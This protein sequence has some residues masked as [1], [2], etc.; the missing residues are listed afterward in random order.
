MDTDNIYE[1]M[2]STLQGFNITPRSANRRQSTQGIM[3]SIT[4]RTS[5]VPPQKPGAAPAMPTS[6]LRNGHH[7]LHIYAH[8]HNTHI[9]LTRP[10]REPILSYSAGNIGFRKAQRGSFDAAFQLAA[11][12]MRTISDKGLLR[13]TV[14]A[15][16]GSAEAARKLEAP[17][18]EV[19]VVLRG[20][21]KGREAVVKALLGAEGRFLRE[22]I[23]YVSDDTKLKFGG[24]RSPNPRR[25]G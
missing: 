11:Y 24:T 2:T 15:E 10:N 22:K 3:D 8:K 12:V 9:V 4:S 25:L 18:K 21:G 5:M 20:W 6:P 13:S 16:G 7:H 23:R 14:F 1:Q 19:E 17:I